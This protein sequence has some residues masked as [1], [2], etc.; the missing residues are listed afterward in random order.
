MFDDFQCGEVT[1]RIKGSVI[2]LAA[3]LNSTI[4][5]TPVTRVYAPEIIIALIIILLEAIANKMDE[6]RCSFKRSYIIL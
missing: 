3:T 5:L 2:T 4:F 1:L 6:K